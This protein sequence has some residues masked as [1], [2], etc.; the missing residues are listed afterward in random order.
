M[1]GCRFPDVTPGDPIPWWDM[2]PVGNSGL[3]SGFIPGCRNVE[4]L[5][6]SAVTSVVRAQLTMTEY[7]MIGMEIQKWFFR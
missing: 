3:G 6:P 7:L 4:D 1:P 2:S 5:L